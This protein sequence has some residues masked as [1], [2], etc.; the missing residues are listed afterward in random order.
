VV[1]AGGLQLNIFADEV[2][3]V[4]LVFDELRVA[5]VGTVA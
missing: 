2:D 5:H 1:H 3:D 4:E